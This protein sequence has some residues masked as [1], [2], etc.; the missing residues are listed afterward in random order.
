MGKIYQDTY[1]VFEEQDHRA[2][3]K[4]SQIMKKLN[5]IRWYILNT[6]DIIQMTGWYAVMTDT[7]RHK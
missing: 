4:I 3:R 1:Y 7:V 2:I 5:Q 6:W